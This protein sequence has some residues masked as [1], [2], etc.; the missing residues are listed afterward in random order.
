MARIILEHKGQVLKDF[1][2]HKGSLTIGRR[3]DNTIVFND[4]QVSASHARIDKRGSD[5]ILTDLQSTNGT[6]VNDLKVFSH[7]L[8]HGD[9]ISVSKHD[10]LFIGTEKAKI[11]AELD[12]VPLDRT[13]IIGGARQRKARSF[14]ERSIPEPPIDQPKTS[15]FLRRLLFVLLLVAV[16]L[17]FGLWGLQEEPS[18]FRGMIFKGKSDDYSD[19]QTFPITKQDPPQTESE[20]Q[21][22]KEFLEV[23]DL[24][25]GLTI[26][27]IVWSSDG[28][29]SFA[30]I[31]GIKVTV[32]QPIEGMTVTEIGRD[33]VLLRPPD[34]QSTIRLTLTLN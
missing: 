4:P 10:L 14:A 19:L 20:Q 34:G 29:N 9:R 30:L 24:E 12:K 33:Y 5:Y 28:A 27:A 1:P 32:G 2:L 25:S 8:H 3:K 16:I 7:R 17:G 21:V 31:N 11:D 13:V 23:S 6:F 22:S 15:G 26:D 18:F